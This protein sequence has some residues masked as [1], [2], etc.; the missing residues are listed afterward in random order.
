MKRMVLMLLMI[1]LASPLASAEG[2][3]AAGM[4][5]A[6]GEERPVDLD[7]TALSDTVAFSLVYDMLDYPENYMGQKIRV[8]GGFSYY[9][10]PDTMQEYFAA[11]VSDATAC[12]AE[13]IEFV[14]SGEHSYPQDYP[15]LYTE[16]T[17][18]GIFS[19]YYE[20]D[21]MYIQLQDAQVEWDV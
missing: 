10:D 14:W 4:S 7:M 2:V 21:R 11:T 6:M 15:P 3:G 5:E 8:K 13:G 12:C 16:I 9:Q 17:V 20:E 18:T 19:T 1:L